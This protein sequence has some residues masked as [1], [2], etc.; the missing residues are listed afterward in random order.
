MSTAERYVARQRVFPMDQALDGTWD[1][2]ARRMAM[3]HAIP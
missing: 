1:T 3:G 2:L